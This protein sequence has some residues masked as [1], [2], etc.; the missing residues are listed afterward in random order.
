[1]KYVKVT[2][3][4]QEKY[5]QEL[6]DGTW[7]VMNE[8]P[9]YPG[10]Y[11]VTVEIQGNNGITV[12]VGDDDP[13]LGEFL[14]LM[15]SGEPRNQLISYMPLY[16][17]QSEVFK[18]LLKTAGIELD[19]LQDSTQVIIDDAYIYSASEARVVEWEKA[20][21]I[22]PAGT[23]AQRKSFI[24]SIIRGQGKLNEDRIKHIVN[25]FTGG[26]AL[27]S[28][29]NSTLLVRILAPALGD[30]YLYP[31]VERSLKTKVSAHITLQVQRFYST[32]ADVKENYTSWADV[33]NLKDWNTLKNYIP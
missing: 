17:R 23:L 8:A 11:P 12:I 15:V 26:D 32:W 19:R 16:L 28:F 6:P 29:A 9:S 24:V 22:I 20:L 7:S 33:A 10:L 4:G 2:V 30:V 25:A 3:N 31:D 13:E 21:R 1:M 14:R 18:D 27:V 5:L